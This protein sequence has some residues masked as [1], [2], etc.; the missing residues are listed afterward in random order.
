[1]SEQIKAV[2]RRLR[3]LRLY[4]GMIDGQIGTATVDAIAAFQTSKDLPATGNLTVKTRRLL[5]EYVADMKTVH[6]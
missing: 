1:M 2:Q 6:E 4:P 3:E 5:L